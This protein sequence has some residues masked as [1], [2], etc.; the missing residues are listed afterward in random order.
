LGGRGATTKEVKN[1]CPLDVLLPTPLTAGHTNALGAVCMAIQ[2]MA[3][4]PQTAA[5]L[6]GI[7]GEQA[8]ALAAKCPTAAT[9]YAY[10]HSLTAPMKQR[11]LRNLS[12]LRER[13]QSI[14]LRARQAVQGQG[15]GSSTVAGELRE[16][17]DTLHSQACRRTTALETLAQSRL[18]T[19]AIGLLVQELR[20]TGELQKLNATALLDVLQSAAVSGDAVLRAQVVRLVAEYALLQLHLSASAANERT[21]WLEGLHRGLGRQVHY[22][23]MFR[24]LMD[25]WHKWQTWVAPE[26]AG[27]Y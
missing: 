16:V 13:L 26:E 7:A 11:Q 6:R 3:T 19:S 8:K 15:Q 5:A 9:Q 21:D 25:W 24:G 27:V 10:V 22:E 18:M 23:G 14:V 12:N 17:L 4:S 20:D 1:N 2:C